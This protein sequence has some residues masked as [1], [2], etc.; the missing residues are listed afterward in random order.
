MSPSTVA[1]I[2]RPLAEFWLTTVFGFAGLSLRNDGV[3]VNPQLLPGGTALTSRFNG[4][5]DTSRSG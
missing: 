4:V 1:F 2:S 5:A 3:G